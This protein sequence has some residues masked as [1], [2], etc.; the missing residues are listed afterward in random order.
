MKAGDKRYNDKTTKESLDEIDSAFEEMMGQFS[1]YACE[2]CG[3]LNWTT[4]GMTEE[5][6]EE[7]ERHGNSKIYDKCW[8]GYSK[9]KGKKP[10]N[11]VV[12]KR[13]KQLTVKQKFQMK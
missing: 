7:G 10:V 12:V 6:I 3:N 2:D 13:T 5:E 8:K 11:Q 1:E 4:L 9:V